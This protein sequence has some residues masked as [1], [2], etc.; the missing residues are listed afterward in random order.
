MNQK[1][2]NKNYFLKKHT[3]KIVVIL[4]I[5]GLFG[6]S[7]NFLFK[8]DENK[9]KKISLK[10]INFKDMY[11]EGTLAN[12]GIKDGFITGKIENVLEKDIKTIVVT[13]KFY[14]DNGEFIYESFDRKTNFKQGQ[15]LIIEALLPVEEYKDYKYEI[16]YE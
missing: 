14:D 8:D 10:D 5:I 16:W 3:L 4:L 15:V 13:F 7:L 11:L 6:I 2:K 1:N 12:E 9:V